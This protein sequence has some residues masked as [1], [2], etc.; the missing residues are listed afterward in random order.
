MQNY[1]LFVPSSYL[2]YSRLKNFN[3]F[4]SWFY[5]FP[6]FCYLSLIIFS[7]YL[8]SSLDLLIL[9]SL[10]FISVLCVYEIGYIFND[11]KSIESESNPTLRVDDTWIFQNY[12]LLILSRIISLPV[13]ALFIIA[14]NNSVCFLNVFP[15]FPY[16]LII[17]GMAFSIHNRFR[18]PSNIVTFCLLS[19]LKY[20]S[21]IF[22]ILDK[23]Y[24]IVFFLSFTLIRTLEYSAGKKYI[25]GKISILINENIDKFRASYYTLLLIFLT[26]FAI[27]GIFNWKYILIPLYF[28]SYRMLVHCLDLRHR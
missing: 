19:F 5:L 7:N 22:L 24:F 27:F 14:W 25:K 11:L 16:F 28:W 15:W 9:F 10:I 8:C 4:L 17:L 3:E 21:V 13:L 6:L 26:F 18:G 2:I 20:Y 1:L 12:K 23:I